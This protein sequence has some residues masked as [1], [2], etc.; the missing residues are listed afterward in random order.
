MPLSSL[1]IAIV[2]AGWGPW[3]VPGPILAPYD[4]PPFDWQSG[5]R[6]VDLA[7][8]PGEPVVAMA[9]GTV[10]FAGSVGG[11]PVVTVRYPGSERLRSTYEPVSAL[12]RVGQRVVAGQRLGVV[13]AAGGHCSGRCLHVGLR[14]DTRY[15]DPGSLLAR[16]AAVLK[17]I[18]RRKVG[19]RS[20]G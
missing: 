9:A 14:T 4:P 18:A 12:V 17:P 5:H 11:V 1:L 6:G 16:P 3:P 20:V 7:A 8:M 2:F 10:A 13:A 15:L 19:Y